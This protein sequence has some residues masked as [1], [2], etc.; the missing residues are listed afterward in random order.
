M[1]S[2][3]FSRVNVLKQQLKATVRSKS[4]IISPIT[5]MR[6][7]SSGPEMVTACKALASDMV[8]FEDTDGCLGT[9]IFVYVSSS[10]LS[11]LRSSGGSPTKEPGPAQ[12]FFLSNGAVPCSCCSFRGQ[13]L[14]LRKAP[15]GNLGDAVGVKM[16]K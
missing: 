5:L 8:P 2:L 9:R 15:G 16:N 10:P 4:P 13:A 3:L 12:G 6:M 14:A 1:G 7:F 11:P